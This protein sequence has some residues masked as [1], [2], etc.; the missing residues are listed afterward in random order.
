MSD[1][2]FPREDPERNRLSGRLAR[3]ARVGAN[4][5]GAGLA[6]AAQ[7]LFGGE[8][9]DQRI[10]RA[11]AGALG[12][13]KGPLMKIA[14]LVSTIPDFLPPEYAA[15]L[16]QLQAQAPAM[17]WPF[18]KRRMRAELG[19]GWE[20]KFACFTREAAH[21]ASLGQVHRATLKDGRLVACKLQ[22]PDMASA[23]ESDVGQLRT[24]LGLFKR[25]DGSINPDAMVE[26]I[27]DRLREELDY[28][29][30]ARHMVLYSAM[31]ADKSFVTVPQPVPELCA[32]RLLTMT[33]LTG[34]KLSGF[35]TAPQEMRNRIAEMLFWT[36]W[37]PMNSYAVI[38]GDPH[39]GNYQITGGGNGI[40]L[41]DFG[42]VRIFPAEFVGGVVDLYRALLHNDFDAACAA[43]E[44]WGFENL[45]RELVE[46][47][48]VWARFIY[49]PIIDDRV[50][51]VADGVRPGDYG[52]REALRVRQLLKEKGPVK[53]PREFVFMDR[54]A[55][56][57]GAAYLRLG[58]ELNFHRL[59]E[60]SLDGFSVETVAAR[61]AGALKAAGL[62]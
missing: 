4:L 51:T 6:F 32:D 3:T 25:L 54:A 15:E 13:S 9:G 31:L 55:I 61:Q 46:V 16:G 26:E 17:G 2:P 34:E 7:S 11:L 14:Q 12:R 44:T 30:E 8:E 23:V 41:L 1:T 53:I 29:R 60:L 33:W 39:L 24:L 35:E 10:A 43:Y 20:A 27:T 47:L 18:V 57:L 45:S 62:S 40:N 38:H 19:P 52:R 50:R 5:S 58:A 42:C 37:A 22:Y 48:N 28:S 59:F 36:W 56:G 49:G 21:A